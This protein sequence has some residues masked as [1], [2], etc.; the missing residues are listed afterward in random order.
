MSIKFAAAESEATMHHLH[1]EQRF[2]SIYLF[3]GT[4]PSIKVLHSL[5][6]QALI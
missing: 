5:N 4:G 1:V 6:E 3:V 2:K